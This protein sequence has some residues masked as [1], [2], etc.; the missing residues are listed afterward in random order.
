MA[1]K[2]IPDLIVVGL[3]PRVAIDAGDELITRALQADAAPWSINTVLLDVFKG[4]RA[5]LVDVPLEHATN[6]SLFA[7]DFAEAVSK[8]LQVV[9][10]V[11]PDHNGRLP[12]E[13]GADPAFIEV[14]PVLKHT[15]LL[16][17]D[18][19]DSRNLQ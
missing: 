14:Q 9:Q 6:R 5:V 12:F 8:P 2:G 13:D 15:A 19:A 17:S 18:R 10:L 1:A 3:N 7:L 4:N 16:D 11:W